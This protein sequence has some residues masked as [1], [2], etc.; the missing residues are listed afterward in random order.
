MAN[1][2]FRNCF[3]CGD[4]NPAGLHL[5]NTYVGEKSHMELEITPELSGLSGLMHGGFTCM[6]LD[7]VMYYAIERIRVKTVTLTMTVNYKAPARV[8]HHL[9]CEGWIE[10]RDGK[11]INAAGRVTDKTNDTVIAEAQG[12]YY[13]INLEKF[14]NL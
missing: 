2:Y 11:K 7:E 9:V 6:L 13:E 3:I 14:L 10:S 12:K 8:G 1:T 4:E 5:K